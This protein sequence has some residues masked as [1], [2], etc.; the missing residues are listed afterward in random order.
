MGIPATGKEIV[1]R[2]INV[3]RVA[4]G[5]VQECWACTDILGMMQQL[6]VIPPLG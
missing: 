2:G 1:V 5:K 3:L 4:D 6:G